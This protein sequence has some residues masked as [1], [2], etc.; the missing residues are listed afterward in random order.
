MATA[1]GATERARSKL[2]LR[3]LA[4]QRRLVAQRHGAIIVIGGNDR[5]AVSELANQLTEWFDSRTVRVCA[6]DLA[7]PE[8]RPFL[9][10][11]W[12]DVPAR[13]R[14]TIVVGDWLT[15]TLTEAGRDELTD[16]ALRLR[17]RSLRSFEETLAADGT[18]VVKVW[19]ET[20]EKTLR[21]R[22]REAEDTDAEGWVVTEE[23]LLLAKKGSLSLARTLRTLGSGKNLPWK[24]VSGAA[25]MKLRD[26]HAGLAIAAQLA[27]ASRRRP[28]TAVTRPGARPR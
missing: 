11:Y 24:A 1:P 9:W 21:R 5:L 18:S 8:G 12:Q 15:R 16:P 2:H 14:I 27:Q 20:P 7:G 22:L 19:L 6:P 26:L 10:P 4:A 13:G 25:E 23:D 17:L 28:A 3:L